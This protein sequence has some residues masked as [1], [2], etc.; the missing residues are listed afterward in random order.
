MAP[1]AAPAAFVVVASSEASAGSVVV[2]FGDGLG[3]AGPGL[4]CSPLVAREGPS[5]GG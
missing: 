2:A 3:A 5:G 1:V 4:P